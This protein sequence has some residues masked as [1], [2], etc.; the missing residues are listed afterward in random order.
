MPNLLRLSCFLASILMSAALSGQETSTASDSPTETAATPAQP[1]PEQV[2]NWIQELSAGQFVARETATLKLIEAGSPVIAV[3]VKKLP[4]SNPESTARIIHILRQLALDEEWTINDPALQALRQIA[5]QKGTAAGRRAAST[6][7]KLGA[8]REQ[9]AIREITQLGGNISQS[10]IQFG[11]QLVFQRVIHLGPEWHGAPRD[12]QRLKWIRSAEA[13][14]FEGDQVKDSWM[15]HLAGMTQLRSLAIKRAAITDKGMESLSELKNLI[16]LDIKYVPISDSS[17]VTLQNLTQLRY[18]KLY[19]TKITKEAAVKLQTV[20]AVAEVDHRNGAFLGV[21]CPQPPEPCIITSIQP[22]TAA[23]KAGLRTGDW[24]VSF[25]G[26]SV[27]DFNDLKKLIGQ[28]RPGD[29]TT[30]QIMRINSPKFS[31]L[32]K[33]DKVTADLDVTKHPLG[34][35]INKLDE[36]SP[37]YQA[38]L[39]ADDVIHKLGSERIRDTAAFKKELEGDGQGALLQ[40]IYYRKPQLQK[41]NLELGAWQ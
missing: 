3:L 15:P 4:G 32:R 18:I 8:L 21:G 1:S 20:L 23:E 10:S 26:E 40:V 11:L 16:S 33:G 31:N 41:Y 35:K 12:L 39:R 34:I 17:L 19:G 37:W 9:R 13:V 36:K 14:V 7:L 38:G 5:K 25:S 27:S 22:G 28:W 6:L 29:K 30:V 24:I 2:S